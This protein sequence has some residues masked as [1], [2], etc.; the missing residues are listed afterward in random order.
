MYCEKLHMD[1]QT[2]EIFQKDQQRLKKLRNLRSVISL[3]V[4][5]LFQ[6]TFHCRCKIQACQISCFLLL[7]F[8]ERQRQRQWQRQ[9]Q[10]ERDRER[11]LLPVGKCFLTTSTRDHSLS[12]YAIFSEKIWTRTYQG[13]KKFCVRNELLLRIKSLDIIDIAITNLNNYLKLKD[14]RFLWK[15][16]C[17]QLTDHMWLY[18]TMILQMSMKPQW[19]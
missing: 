7:L 6:W 16:F 4:T 18:T 13:V 14:I 3:Q 19:K 9:R 2:F 10:R 12:T 5:T 1:V 15:V 17:P 8:W 11:A